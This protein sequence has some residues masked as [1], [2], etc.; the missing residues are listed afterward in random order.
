MGLV[1]GVV[2]RAVVQFVHFGASFAML[3]VFATLVTPWYP[4]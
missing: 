4:L 3:A 1:W 2:G